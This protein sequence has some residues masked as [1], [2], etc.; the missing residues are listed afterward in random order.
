MSDSFLKD[1]D[2]TTVARMEETMFT[3]DANALHDLKVAASG[4]SIRIWLPEQK[5]SFSCH[6]QT[7]TLL[8][9][10][11]MIE[12]DRPDAVFK[13]ANLLV[14]K[15]GVVKI[16]DFG[17]AKL[18]GTEGVK[19]NGHDGRHGGLY[20]ARAGKGPRGRSPVDNGPASD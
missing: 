16:L 10:E 1:E 7:K 3:W 20:V 14:T 19:Q 4:N 2:D 8:Q 5:L 17:L 13:P 11:E 6:F 15:T 9:I 12:S 18:V